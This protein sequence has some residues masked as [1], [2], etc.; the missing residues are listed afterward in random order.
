MLCCLQLV[1]KLRPQTS[2]SAFTL[3]ELLVV[4]AIMAILAAMLLPAMVRAKAQALR[5]QCFS[6]QRQIGVA[7]HLYADEANDRYPVHDGWAATGGQRPANP[8]TAG[9][10][11]EY[12]GGEWETNRPL[13]RYA[14]NVQVFRCPADKGD[15]LNPT[16]QSCWEGWGNSYLVGWRVDGF[17]VKYVTGSGGRY[18]ARNEPMK[19][20]EVGRKPDTK[21][22]QGDWPWHAN[23][24]LH[25]ARSVW[26]NVRGQRAEAMLFGDGHVESFKFPTAPTHSWFDPP[27]INYLWW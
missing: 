18:F 20:L 24:S 21:I 16:P 4:I 23:R 26:H 27:D 7:F 12:G 22:I 8:Y 6:N 2:S 10:A 3:I 1:M 15:A 5:T 25:D 14:G 17:R 19:T 13:N 11:F 9:F